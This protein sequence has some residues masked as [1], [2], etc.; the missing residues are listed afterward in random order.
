MPLNIHIPDGEARVM[1]DGRIYVYGSLDE[2]ATEYCSS[3]YVVAYSDDMKDWTISNT[4]FSSKYIDKKCPKP[5]PVCPVSQPDADSPSCRESRAFDLSRRHM[6]RC[7]SLRNKLRRLFSA[8]KGGR[9]LYAPDAL[10]SDGKY[11]LYYCLSDNSEGV[12]ISDDPIGPF[13]NIGYINCMGIDPAVFCDDDGQLYYYWGQFHGKVGKLD[14]DKQT[15]IAD[16]VVETLTEKEHFFHEGFSIRKRKGIYYAVFSCTKRGRPTCLGYA[17]ST[18]P[19]GPFV[20]RGIIIDNIDCDPFSWNNHGSIEQFNGQWYVFY[21]RS[22]RGDRYMRRLCIEPIYFNEDGTI[23]EVKMTSQ[24]VGAPFAIGEKIYAFHACA[25]H[26]SARLMPHGYNDEILT[27]IRDHDSAT[28]R[29]VSCDGTK[30][31]AQIEA[32]GSAVVEL[33]FNDTK[34]GYA[35]VKNGIVCDSEF[36]VGAGTYELKCVFNAPKRFRFYSITL[37]A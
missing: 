13:Q 11:Y 37:N 22:S 18:S 15:I 16:S 26:G 29:Y 12:A 17:T 3:R 1:P 2:N 24:G 31:K 19:L 25:L 10:H 5:V 7:D 30:G 4:S 28:F 21:H 35:V 36:V 32:V 8:P 33:Y 20:Y 34:C 14:V 27:D 6:Y 9:L 23:P